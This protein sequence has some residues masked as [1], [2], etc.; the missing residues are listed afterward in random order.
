MFIEVIR[1][2]GEQIP[3]SVKLEVRGSGL[4]YSL[5]YEAWRWDLVVEPDDERYERIRRRMKSPPLDGETLVL[6]SST[7][8]GTI[9]A[10]LG[11]GP[12]V[13]FLP[14]AVAMKLTMVDVVES[15]QSAVTAATKAP[16][17]GRGFR[18][19]AEQD[20]EVVRLWFGDE[21][22]NIIPAAT[23]PLAAW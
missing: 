22:G 2:L 19:R 14:K 18:V 9:D 1:Q 13:P 7:T 3:K 17:P 21:Q 10:P 5:H 11:V 6:P 16:W 15:V 12:W 20:G 4:G 23:L 8:L